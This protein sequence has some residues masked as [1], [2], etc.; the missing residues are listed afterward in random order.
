[1]PAAATSI[2]E[3][4][5][6][7]LGGTGLFTEVSLGRHEGSTAVPRAHVTYEGHDVFLSDDSSGNVWVRLQARV[8]VR[9]RSDDFAEGITRAADL[10]ASVADALLADPYRGQRC[11]HLPIGPATQIGQTKMTPGIRRPEVEMTFGVC[12]HFEQ[13]NT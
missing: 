2:L 13:E 10:C 5:V 4:I 1:M 3:D 9:T 7:T 8:A 12:C 11:R 6:S